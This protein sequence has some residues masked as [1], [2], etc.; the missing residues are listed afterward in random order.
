MCPQRPIS[1]FFIERAINE[2]VRFSRLSQPRPFQTVIDV[3]LAVGADTVKAQDSTAYASRSRDLKKEVV[4]F[5]EG[6]LG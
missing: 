1:R 5:R 4:A 6:N 3:D 2:C